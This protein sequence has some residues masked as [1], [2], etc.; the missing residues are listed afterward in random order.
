MAHGGPLAAG[1][2]LWV[3][4]AKYY[5]QFLLADT[6]GRRRV[7]EYSGVVEVNQPVTPAVDPRDIERLLARNLACEAGQVKLIDWSRLH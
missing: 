5:T 2:N 4:S 3:V 1:N 6:A 7:R